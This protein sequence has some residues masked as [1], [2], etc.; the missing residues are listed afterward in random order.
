MSGTAN[1]SQIVYDC[2]RF[3]KKNTRVLKLLSRKKAEK[4]AQLLNRAYFHGPLF[5]MAKEVDR[6]R[7]I[8]F[9]RTGD[10]P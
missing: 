1:K 2:L 8:P 7:R 3:F 9:P 10:G 5:D 4:D 6:N